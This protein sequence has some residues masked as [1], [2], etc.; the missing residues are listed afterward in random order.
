MAHQLFKTLK[1]VIRGMEIK[2]K[3]SD[4]TPT[5]TSNFF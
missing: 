4:C 3:R 2:A 5:A 1:F